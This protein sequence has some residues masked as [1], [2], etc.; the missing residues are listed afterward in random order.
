MNKTFWLVTFLLIIVIGFAVWKEKR[1]KEI[2][3]MVNKRNEGNILELS[4][5]SISKTDNFYN[6]KVEYPQ[7]KN[8]DSAFNQKI[9]SLVTG[10]I[11]AFKKDSKDNWEARRATATPD[12]PVPKNPPTPFDF[13]ASW[14]PTQLNKNYLSF[15]INIYYYGGGAHGI[16]E[17]DAFN[18]DVM[19]EKE[20]SI[21]DFL[22]FSQPALEKLSQL[23]SE[24]V[25]SKIE[26]SGV[27]IDDNLKQMISQGTQP[28]TDNYQNFNF[29]YNSL[30]I[31]FQQYQVA[32]GY[33]GPVTITLYKENLV[34]NSINSEYLQ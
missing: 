32:P 7:F 25:T 3:I 4:S 11:E 10:E 19:A 29:N 9:S 8:I 23:S 18:Y 1:I 5:N 21:T 16:T 14:T 30:T 15:V 22:G 13:I 6:I 24:E 17:V 31:Y 34:S 12:N 28:T 26:S 33:I 20:I 2:S 27:T